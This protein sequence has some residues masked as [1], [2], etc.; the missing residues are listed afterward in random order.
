MA[1]LRLVDAGSLV[2]RVRSGL[3]ASVHRRIAGDDFDAAHERIWNTPGPRRFTP[4]H[5]I[6][7][8]HTDTAMFVGGIRALL[9]QSLHPVAMQAVSDHSGF[10]GDP[11]G[12]LHR[13]SHYL[14]TTTYGTDHDASRAIARVRGIHRRV[15]G[16]MPD[17]TPYR[18]DDP[19]LL[20]WVHI[21]E[22]DSFLATHQR[23]GATPL[24]DAGVDDYLAD[25]AQVAA[26]LGVPEPPTD[27]RM[28]D[29]Q[30]ASFR[31]ELRCTEPARE[32]RDLLLR[33]PPLPAAARAGYRLL[34]A[35]AIA[36]L[37][38][39]ARAELSLPTLPVTDRV[40]AAP[41]T[42]LALGA[43]RWA[44]AAPTDDGDDRLAT[45]DA[46]GDGTADRADGAA[47][48]PGRVA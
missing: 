1:G 43:L 23:Y 24:T 8:V 10:R 27:R 40:L 36:T 46:T 30:L 37:P 33:N 3:A 14:A 5:A 18:A 6:W 9:L 48:Q 32:A 4:D 17:G 39:W 21:A 41:A 28:L 20:T 22:V 19:R 11:W 16:T 26:D 29:R 2:H 38:A 42:R 34:A 7:R 13:T 12:R 15:H 47:D 31:P 35:G 45:G 44:L 25:T